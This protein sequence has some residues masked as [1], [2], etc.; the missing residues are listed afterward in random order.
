MA[1]L[2]V[3]VEGAC[4]PQEQEKRQGNQDGELD[5]RQASSGAA[6]SILASLRL[7]NAATGL[8]MPAQDAE[9]FLIHRTS[10]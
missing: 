2:G 1:G 9:A 4:R 10:K 8:A 7:S 5:G 6:T 3:P